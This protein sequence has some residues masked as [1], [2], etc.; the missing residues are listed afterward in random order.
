V[1]SNACGNTAN[2]QNYAATQAYGLNPPPSIFSVS[3]PACGS[4]V[5]A[6]YTFAF[7]TTLRLGLKAAK[8]LGITVPLNML[9][10]ADQVI[11]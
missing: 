4:Q 11:E 1:N 5:T 8:A 7:V 6:N 2:I 9:G 3:T 10:R